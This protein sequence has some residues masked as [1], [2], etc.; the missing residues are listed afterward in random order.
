MSRLRTLPPR[1]GTAPSRL[2]EAGTLS[3][4]RIAGGRLT[5]RRLDMWS[6]DPH[7]KRCGELTTYPSGFQLDHIVPLTSGGHDV[8]ANCQV[9]CHPCHAVKTREDMARHGSRGKGSR[10]T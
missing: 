6:T 3:S 4:K 9:L 10:F 7:C 5:A 1:L 8:E 2:K